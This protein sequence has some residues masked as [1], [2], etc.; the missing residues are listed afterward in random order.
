MT[1]SEPLF[2]VVGVDEKIFWVGVGGGGA[3]FNNAQL[4]LLGS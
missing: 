1:V 4:V 3:L 2:W